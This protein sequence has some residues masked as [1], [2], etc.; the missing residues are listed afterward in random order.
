VEQPGCR[1]QEQVRR[2]LDQ[3]P[4]RQLVLHPLQLRNRLNFLMGL[5]VL[6]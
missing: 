2:R 1:Q 3:R 4:D 5:T 6:V